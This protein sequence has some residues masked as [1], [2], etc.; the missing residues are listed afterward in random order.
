M[1]LNVFNKSDCR[2]SKTESFIEVRNTKF[3]SLTFG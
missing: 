3:K 2:L 1:K